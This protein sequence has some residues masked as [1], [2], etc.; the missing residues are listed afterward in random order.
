VLERERERESRRKRDTRRDIGGHSDEVDV[1]AAPHAR[2]ARTQ[3][4]PVAVTKDT[5]K[6]E[7]K[8]GK[9]LG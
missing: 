4:I 1:G 8:R 6:E 5:G 2:V 7:K 3:A 9:E